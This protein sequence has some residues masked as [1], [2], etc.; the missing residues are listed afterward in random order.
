MQEVELRSADDAPDEP[1]VRVSH[2]GRRWIVAVAAAGVVALAVTQGVASS[3]ERAALARLAQVPGVLAPVDATLSPG[4]GVPA[5]DPGELFGD[6]GG[7]LDVGDDGAQTFTW[8]GARGWTV[9]L[10]G[11]T[12]ALADAAD[13]AM[14]GSSCQSDEAPGAEVSTAEHV[15]CLVTDGGYLV[16]GGSGVDHVPAT[17]HRVL[18]LSAADG[19]VDADWPVDRGDAL[20]LMPAGVVVLG[21][22]SAQGTAVVAYDELTGTERWRQED[23]LPDGY[24]W[25]DDDLP[26]LGLFRVGDLLAYTSPSRLLVLLSATGETVRDLAAEDATFAG[27]MTDSDGRIVLRSQ[28]ADGGIRSTFVAADGDPDHDVTVDGEGLSV[29]V[30]DGSLPGLLLTSGDALDAWDARTGEARWSYDTSVVTGA[31]VVRGRVYFLG[32]T[33]IVAVDGRTGELLWTAPYDEDL[34]ATTLLT[35]GRHLLVPT[36]ATSAD[37]TSA[38]VAYDLVDG[39][40]DF[41]AGYPPGIADLGPARRAIVG[42]DEKTDELVVLD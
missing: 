6:L 14:S 1:P 11:P 25:S 23:P 5:N 39:H 34:V 17:V 16:D 26:S 35:D 7:S 15:V 22:S 2:R 36:E 12:P 30:D 42:H 33:G 10:L 3:R 37:A 28:T 18:V 24:G 40:V 9:P 31:L 27:W 8:G 21:S 13:H 4:R 41:R 38:L 19:T 20:A 32:S 29:T